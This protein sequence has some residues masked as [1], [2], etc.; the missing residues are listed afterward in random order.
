MSDVPRGTRP[1]VNPDD[2]EIRLSVPMTIGQRA[3]LE[4]L[5]K[6]NG[7]NLTKEVQEALS[8]WIDRSKSDPKVLARAKAV[9]DEIDR[10]A[11]TKRD[12]LSAIFDTKLAGTPAEAPE[13]TKP[14]AKGS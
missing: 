2:E 6:V 10:E 7:R 8:S 13:V 14:G 4:V 3:Q 12:A 1:R 9:S 5:A 11:A